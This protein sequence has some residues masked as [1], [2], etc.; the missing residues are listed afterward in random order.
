MTTSFESILE[1][2]PQPSHRVVSIA[3]QSGLSFLEIAS[4]FAHLP[5]TVTL[6]SGGAADCARYNIMGIHPWLSLKADLN[7]VTIESERCSKTIEADPLNFLQYI[8]RYY[9]LPDTEYPLPI[10]AGLMGYLSYDLKDCIEVL[11]RTSIEDLHLPHLYMVAPSIILVEDRF[12]KKKTLYVSETAGNAQ[13]R[14][15]SFE[16][17]LRKGVSAGAAKP[18]ETGTGLKSGFA[19]DEYMRSIETIRDYIARGHVYQVNMSQRFET[20]FKGDAFTLFSTLFQR[21]PAPF[22]AYIN[23]G[24]HHIVSTSPERFIEARGR[25]VETRPI[26]GTK[27]RGKTPQ[28]DAANRDQLA[29]SRKDDAELSMIVDLLRNDIGKVCSAGSVKVR[30]HKRVEAYEN[31]FHLVSIIDGVL[32]DDKDMVDLV[33]ATFPGGSITGCPKIRSM[34]IID[35]LEPVRRHIYTGSIGYIGFHD[36]MDLSIAIRT[37]TIKDSRLVYSVGGGIVYDSDPADEFEETLHKGQTLM[38]AISGVSAKSKKPSL[39]AWY[40][41]KFMPLEGISAPVTGD[42]FVYGYGIFETIRVQNGVPCRLEQHLQRFNKSWQH[43]FG[44]EPPD[45]TWNDIIRQVIDRSG[46]YEDVAA[47]KVLAAAGESGKPDTMSMMVT[48]RPYVHRL[49]TVGRDGLYCAAYPNRRYSHL[50]S[51]KTMNYMFSKIANQWAKKQGAD[52]AIILNYD[53]SVSETATANILCIIDGI[54]Y[55]PASEH[56]LPG[57]MEKAVCDLL[58]SRGE[59]VETRLITLDELKKADCVFMTN[60]LMGVVSVHRIDGVSI[61]GGSAA[62]LCEELNLTV[63]K[64]PNRMLYT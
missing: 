49:K 48:A 59:T 19:R 32:D 15:E 41:G 35:E 47:V 1:F 31:V 57:T 38:H 50:S 58:Q 33:R 64:R 43:F 14:I 2:L 13:Q 60:A 22:F 17:A 8:C 29:N 55:R 21:N 45:V 23:A 9:K 7:R 40:N 39:I 26:K 52:E 4:R 54:W 5:G 44:T 61:G 10:C 11:P 20:A 6:I 12:E 36:T 56:V 34:E 30:E 42:G 25:R 37:A 62:D 18:P 24:D 46:L 51:H 3:L 16:Y 27:P 53:G 63:M 28:E